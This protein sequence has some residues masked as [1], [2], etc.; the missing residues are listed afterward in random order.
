MKPLPVL[1]H[2]HGCQPR[3]KA[4][5]AMAGSSPKGCVPSPEPLRPDNA[6]SQPCAT[7]EVTPGTS[8][9]PPPRRCH[10]QEPSLCHRGGA[11]AGCQPCATKEVTSSSSQAHP[12]ATAR[13]EGTTSISPSLCRSLGHGQTPRCCFPPPSTP[14]VMP[15]HPHGPAVGPSSPC[16]APVLISRCSTK[17][18]QTI[19]G[20]R[21]IIKKAALFLPDI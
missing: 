7:E 10:H 15:Q 17:R 14:E 18:F 5:C 19:S 12:R 6:R 11:N 13:L 2:L 16:R 9:V 1:F 3:R 20:G 4:P 8:P 21:R